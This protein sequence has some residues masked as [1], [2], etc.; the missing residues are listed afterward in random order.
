MFK[1]DNAHYDTLFLNKNFIGDL[2]LLPRKDQEAQFNN[3]IEQWKNGF[4]KAIII[5]GDRLSGKSTFVEYVGEKHFGKN[6]VY[7]KSDATITFGGRKFSTT[8]NLKEALQNIKK[9]ISNVKPLIVIDDLELWRN[10]EFSLL[11]NTRALLSFITSESDNA[12][13]VVTTSK[14]MQSHLDKRLRFSEAFSTTISL[15]KASIEEIHKAILLRHGASHKELVA[16]NQEPFT[17]K[18]IEQCI[19]KL[20]RKL[21]YNMGEI[22]QAWTYGTTLLDNNKVIYEDK[23]IGFKDFFNAEEIIILKYTMLHKTFNEVEFK[24]FFSKSYETTYKPS[25]KRLTNTKVLLRDKNGQLKLNPVVCMDI[26]Q[27]LIY[28]GILN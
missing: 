10:S 5:T 1:E 13:I 9:G 14:Q 16:I 15:N 24:S 4:N 26:K 6:T 20:S 3:S 21:N 11:E 17:S 8:K 25:L 12:F 19:L 23:D 18:Q 27:I 28:K 7:V 22:L 2:F